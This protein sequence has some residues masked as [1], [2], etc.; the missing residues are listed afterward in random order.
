MFDELEYVNDY[1]GVGVTVPQE[2]GGTPRPMVAFV[3]ANTALLD[4]EFGGEEEGSLMLLSPDEARKAAEKLA[5]MADIAER[6][7]TELERE[8]AEA[9]RDV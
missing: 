8:S 3:A 6:R 2:M 1:L 7:L 4:E 5:R 9:G